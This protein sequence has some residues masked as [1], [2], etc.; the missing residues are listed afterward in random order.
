MKSNRAF[1]VSEGKSEDFNK[2]KRSSKL[3]SILEKAKKLNI[4]SE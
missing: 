1:I 4:K 2:I 3:D